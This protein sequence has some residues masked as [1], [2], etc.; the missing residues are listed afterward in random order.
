MYL[1][2]EDEMHWKVIEIETLIQVEGDQ[3]VKFIK[4]IFL[5]K[6]IEIM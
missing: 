2:S 5:F 3:N 6:E 4:R 1:K